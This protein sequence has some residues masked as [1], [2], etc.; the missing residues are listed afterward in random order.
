MEELKAIKQESEQPEDEEIKDETIDDGKSSHTF[1][2]Q[3]Y[4][5]GDFVFVETSKEKGSQ[6]SIFLIENIHAIAGEQMIYGNQFFRPIETFHVNT[7]K[8]LENE[9]F[10]SNEYKD[11]AFKDI[12]GRCFVMNVKDYFTRKPEGF[13]D[14]HIF[15]CE[16]R[17]SVKSR[18]FKKMK[19]FWNV[20]DHINLIN[21][22]QVLEP[23]RVMSVFKE[24]IEKHKEELEELASME[25][26]LET[27]IPPN[28]IWEN[29]ETVQGHGDGCVY[30]EQYTIPGPIT[31][32]RG[33]AVFVRA[34]TVS[35]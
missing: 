25:T 29:P 7:R 11:L 24:R 9:V 3:Q 6:P 18:S 16:S 14:K 4:H 5:V 26:T 17:Y 33:D 19:L 23:K 28:I 15:V 27:E 21:R 12:V 31:L 1:N 30:Y 8:F 10:R 22:D 2:Q 20:P 35:P 13:E 32:R 34:E